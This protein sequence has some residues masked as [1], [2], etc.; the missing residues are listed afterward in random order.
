MGLGLQEGKSEGNDD[1][2]ANQEEEPKDFYIIA[3][4]SNLAIFVDTTEVAS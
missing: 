4:A 2:I 3:M 1:G